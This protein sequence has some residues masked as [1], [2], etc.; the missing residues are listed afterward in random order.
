MRRITA[1]IL[2]FVIVGFFNTARA[3]DDYIFYEDFKDLGAWTFRT[4]SRGWPEDCAPSVIDENLLLRFRGARNEFNQVI[5]GTF[6]EKTDVASSTNTV[7]DCRFTVGDSVPVMEAFPLI[8]G[9]AYEGRITEKEGKFFYRIISDDSSGYRDIIEIKPG[10]TYSLKA[11][12]NFYKKTRNI[13]ITNIDEGETETVLDVGYS[14]DVETINQIQLLGYC[15]S[16]G[17]TGELSIDYI[18]IYNDNFAVKEISISE[19]EEVSADSDISITYTKSV[20]E[21]S[22]E[23]ISVTDGYGNEVLCQKSVDEEDS[24]KVNLYFPI[25][26]RYDMSYKLLLPDSISDMNGNTTLGKTVNF[27]T[28]KAPFTCRKAEFLDENDNLAD[29][30]D[31]TGISVLKTHVEFSNM[32]GMVKNVNIITAVFADGK[33]KQLEINP[34]EAEPGE[35]AKTF[36]TAINPIQGKISAKVFIWTGNSLF[37]VF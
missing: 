26:L 27:R 11:G 4:G 16:T 21:N 10:C 12:I 5:T 7:I 20:D 28:N 34:F 18:Y 1:G 19:G 33:L 25:G 9:G 2:L 8:A 6:P 37:N 29:G 23:D 35:A 31:I 13:T 24:K 30:D 14:K 15:N 17:Q 32:S 22:L 36:D 3:E